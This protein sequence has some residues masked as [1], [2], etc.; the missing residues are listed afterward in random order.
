MF[1]TN[2]EI[3]Y[4]R[5]AILFGFDKVPQ[6]LKTPERDGSV[7]HLGLN[8]RDLSKLSCATAPCMLLCCQITAFLAKIA[9]D[10]KYSSIVIRDCADKDIHKDLRNSL[11]P[12]GIV[13]LS[14]FD[15][16]QLWIEPPS[17]PTY[18]MYM[19]SK[20]FGAVCEIPRDRL[21][22]FSGRRYLH[23]TEPWQNVELF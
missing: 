4:L 18:K 1:H 2:D 3:E 10:H 12:Q 16:C 20:I 21:L 23:C 5:Q 8:P 7:L 14:D 15:D 17:G 22:L 11:Y 13:R 19:G 6:R 9:P